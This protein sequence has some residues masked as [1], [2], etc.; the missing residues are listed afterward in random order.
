[1]SRRRN[2]QNINAR[3]AVLFILVILCLYFILALFGFSL[4]GSSGREWGIYLRTAWGGAVLLPL[5]FWLYLCIARLLKFKVPNLPR[6]IL[7]TLQLYVSF[8]FMLGLLRETGWN[9]E[10]TLFAPGNFGQALAHF[11]VLNLGIFITLLLVIV[12]FIL[13]A[14][15]FGLK[16][17]RVPFPELFSKSAQAPEV[18]QTRRRRKTYEAVE[19]QY[20]E[21]RPENILFMK[22]LP[23]SRLKFDDE[24]TAQISITGPMPD[25]FP[26]PKLK[27]APPENKNEFDFEEDIEN[28]TDEDLYSE[29]VNKNV[30]SA[31]KE[32]KNE[33]ESY[34][35][36]IIDSLLAS[37]DAG[38]LS[39]PEKKRQTASERSTPRRNRRPLPVVIFDDGASDSEPKEMSFGTNNSSENSGFPPPMELFGPAPSFELPGTGSKNFDKVSKTIIS[40]LKNF[41]IDASVADILSGPS[42]TQFL[43]ELAP[44]MKVNKVAGLA[45]DLAMALSAVSVRLEAPIPGTRYVGIEIP[46]A[47]RKKITLR[48]VFESE[49]FQANSSRLPIP[50]GIKF[51]GKFLVK[52]LESMPHLLVAGG[53]DSG[54]NTFLNTSI[55]SIC[56]QRKPDELALI[57][58]DPRHVEFALYN[59]LPHLLTPPIFTYDEAL[60][61]LQLIFEEMESR[62]AN[63]V[64]ARV[65]TLSAYNRKLQKKDRLPEI[66]IVIN[67]LSDLMYQAGNENENEFEDLIVRL[68]QKSAVAGIYMIIA[69][70]KPS[71]DVV[72]TL[73]RS[74]ISA[75]AAFSLASGTESKNMIGITDAEKLTGKGDM[76]F[77]D[78][79]A[80][81][82]FRLQAPYINGEKVS[83]FVEYLE[84]ALKKN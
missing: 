5:L 32:N 49:E 18:P 38:A 21:D 26:A 52:G 17:L 37:I 13:S 54:K 23:T 29:N 51:D 20:P 70:Q 16:I 78:S 63:F 81:G 47:E 55:L 44:G 82:I 28:Y 45:D 60:K 22:D 33:K 59:G 57:L 24:D 12:S 7:G 4:T 64:K 41:G 84:R 79:E 56:S 72:T 19:R 36:E 25:D 67:E 65:R 31:Q 61:A 42:V 80:P 71:A 74:N 2:I 76:L 34:A 75:R 69:S 46:N 50:L 39:M 68:A 40:T 15:F 11:F 10:L 6:Q 27:P 8:A 73:I 58:I 48:S 43:I 3:G 83:N 14:F 53:K 35:V 30:P 62:T 9:S 77:K 66:V 1:M